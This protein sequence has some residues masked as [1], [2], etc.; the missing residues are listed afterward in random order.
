MLPTLSARIRK[1]GHLA[2]SRRMFNKG[3]SVAQGSQQMFHKCEQNNFPCQNLDYS[4]FDHVA[5]K[6]LRKPILCSNIL[7]YSPYCTHLPINNEFIMGDLNHKLY[8]KGLNR[9]TGLYHL[10]SHFDECDDHGTHCMLCV[11]VGKGFAE[12]RIDDHIKNKW[13]SSELEMYVTF[14]EMGNRLSKYY[15]QLFLDKYDF[16][17]NIAENPG[18]GDLHA[19]WDEDRFMNGTETLNVSNRSKVTSLED[20]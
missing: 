3:L 20:L 13:P 6:E 8:L 11:Y 15:E 10:W 5:R 2:A 1:G 14:T 9:K 4:K 7:N 18:S 16:L 19:V 17:F 12:G